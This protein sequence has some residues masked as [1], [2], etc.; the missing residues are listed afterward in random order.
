MN[1]LELAQDHDAWRHQY[2][3]LSFTDHKA[4][5]QEIRQLYP[6]QRSFTVRQAYQFFDK[7][8]PATVVELGG[9]DGFLAACVLG[10]H[11]EIEGWINW[12]LIDV[13]QSC[14]DPR[15]TPLVLEEPFWNQ[16]HHAD[17]FV[18][19]HTIEHIKAFELIALIGVLD[20][21]VCLIEA[22]IDD[23][24]T[25]WT[26]HPSTHVLEVGWGVVDEVFATAGYRIDHAW[27]HGRYYT[28]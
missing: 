16:R 12:D 3:T 2:D 11:P 20:V 5:Y 9:W 22:P 25:D 4:I 1:A 14:I 6:N 18:A 24:P 17:A 27:N 10:Q 19:T 13:P 23:G 26:G 21:N 7:S 15:Y 28:R 8:R